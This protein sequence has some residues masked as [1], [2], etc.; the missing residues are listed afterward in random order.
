MQHEN[1]KKKK[2]SLRMKTA[3]THIKKKTKNRIE[4]NDT[5]TNLNR[6]DAARFNA[7]LRCIKIE[8][9]IKEKLRK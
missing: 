7:F 8:M 1:V 6:V 3:P 4:C 9:K 5:K 2:H